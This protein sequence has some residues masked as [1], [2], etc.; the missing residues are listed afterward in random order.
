MCAWCQRNRFFLFS[1]AISSVLVL[2]QLMLLCRLYPGALLTWVSFLQAHSSFSKLK[3]SVTS[4]SCPCL[5]Y[6]SQQKR[7]SLSES[8][9][10]T[11][12]RNRFVRAFQKHFFPGEVG[13]LLMRVVTVA[14]F[15]YWNG[16]KSPCEV[17]LGHCR[18]LMES[19]FPGRDEF[20]FAR[21]QIYWITEEF[22]YCSKL[23][24]T[25]LPLENHL[26]DMSVNQRACLTWH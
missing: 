22:W 18:G 10:R 8:N 2:L 5:E 15:G 7:R 1:Q 4:G 17:K 23:P 21:E 16:L 24:G 20:G 11:L 19:Y 25:A 12:L 26:K 6:G 9:R 13:E 3:A 14:G